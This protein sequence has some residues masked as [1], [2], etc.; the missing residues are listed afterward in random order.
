MTLKGSTIEEA[1]EKFWRSTKNLNHYWYFICDFPPTTENPKLQQND[2]AEKTLPSL[3]V[4]TAQSIH[5][6]TFILKSPTLKHAIT[7]PTQV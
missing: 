1:L 4:L 5:G 7:M 2:P 3:D 6:L